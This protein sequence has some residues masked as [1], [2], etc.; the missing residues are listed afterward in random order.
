[1]DPWRTSNAILERYRGYL[2]ARFRF[3]DPQLQAS[4]KEA[5]RMA[6]LGAGP[7][8]EATPVYRRGFTVRQ[9]AEETTSGGADEGFIR[10]IN[11]DRR[12]YAH[13]EAAI[14]RVLAGRNV[15]VTTGT[16]SG[17]TEAFLLPILFD[18][19]REYLAGTLGPGVRALILYPMNAL[20]NDQR[21]RLREI[22]TQLQEFGS[23]FRFTFGQYI[24]ATPED[25]KDPSRLIPGYGDGRADGELLYREEIRATPPNILL[26]NYSMLEYL[27]IRPRDS[28]LFDGEGAQ[29]WRFLVVD[30]AHQYRGVQ[31][32][33]LALL[34][35]RLKERL[36]S[37]GAAQSLRCIG[38]SATIVGGQSDRP[39]AAEF[40]SQ[41]FGEPFETE[42]V[43]LGETVSIPGPGPAQLP[44]EDYPQL[45]TARDAD[46]EGPVGQAVRWVGADIVPE[47][48]LAEALAAVLTRDARAFRLRQALAEGPQLAADLAGRFFPEQEQGARQR[49]LQAL[50][51]LLAR[52][53]N[54]DGSPLVTLRYHLL[55]SSLEGAF[56]QYRP[57]PRI[58][59]DR[60]THGTE[61]PAFE[62][63]LCRECGEHYLVGREREGRLVEAVHDVSDPAFG[64]T[65]F[66]TARASDDLRVGGASTEGRAEELRQLC[67]SCGALAP[68]GGELPCGHSDTILLE[69]H[70]PPDDHPD[71][72]SSCPACLYEHRDPVQEVVY[73]ADGPQAV[74]VTTL[75]QELPS[76]RRRVL[77]FADSR[78]EAAW[79]AAYV[80]RTY[81]ELASR[82]RILRVIRELSAYSDDGVALRDM[83]P[84]LS[85]I[86]LAERVLPPEVTALGARGQAWIEVYREFLT[87]HR[88]LSLE[89][90]GLIHWTLAREAPLVVPEVLRDEP[91]HLSE[92]EARELCIGLLRTLRAERAVEL[93]ADPT[94]VAWDD[95]N[96]EGEQ[97]TVNL[98]GAGRGVDRTRSWSRSG[99]RGGRR[100]DWLSRILTR[101]APSLPKPRV[102]ENVDRALDLAWDELV[103]ARRRADARDRGLLVRSGEGYRLNPAWWR[104]LVVDGGLFQ[105]DTCG[106]LDVV[107]VARTCPRW[108]CPG[109]LR[110][111]S[112]PL[113]EDDHYRRLYEEPLPPRLRAEEHTAQLSRERAHE[114]QRE[115]KEGEIEL[116]SSSTTF[117]LGVD[118]GDLDAV[119]LRNVP[120]EP[121]NY[122]QRAGRAGR[123]GG[124]PGMVVTYC[125]RNPHDIYHFARPRLAIAGRVVPPTVWTRNAKVATR[126]MMATV[127]ASYFRSRPER[128]RSAQAFMGDPARPNVVEALQSFVD[129][130][131]ERI[132]RRLRT[133][134][135]DEVQP[136]VGLYDLRWTS[137]VV[138]PES[139]LV[140]AVREFAS[141]YRELAR[142]EQELSRA[143]K[144]DDAKWA[145]LRRKTLEDEDVLSFLSRK[146]VI[147][148]Y[149]FP[150][151][152]VE[153]D[154]SFSRGRGGHPSAGVELSRDL[155]VAIAEFAPGSSV[156][157]DK[158]QWVSAGLKVVEEREWPWRRYRR[159]TVHNRME[160]VER[161]AE[162]PPERCCDSTTEGEYVIPAFGFRADDR[163]PHPVRRRPRRLFSTRPHFIK[164]RG[165]TAPA[166]VLDNSALVVSRASP[167]TMLVLCDGRRG[168]G[169]YICPSCGTGLPNRAKTHHNARR[170]P[171]REA[172]YRV[173]LGHEFETDVVSITF[174]PDAQDLLALMGGVGERPPALKLAFSVA[175][176]LVDSLAAILQV[177][178]SD[179]NVTVSAP[180][181]EGGFPDIIVYDDVPGGA[182]LVVRMEDPRV[183]RNVLEE[184][185]SRLDGRCGCGEVDSCYGCLRGF[186][187]QFIH[188]DLC[189]GPAREYVRRVLAANW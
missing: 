154:T 166:P 3:R 17:K 169:F 75:L 111:R 124:N 127:L 115:F 96:L 121:F 177:P 159:C 40:A 85:N 138:G 36:W 161:L 31:G 172:L 109:E 130:N 47:R 52:A 66:R 103:R 26:T 20:A 18:L 122:A 133:I 105:C 112:E 86:L 147:P 129:A 98:C 128:F 137:L 188:P 141:D 14:R 22:S 7:F 53:R 65:Y 77:A 94:P 10:A 19:Y 151:D 173:S 117:E 131:V 29:R 87:Q 184:A 61:A 21:D 106:Y 80:E 180:V 144:Y 32:N 35:R 50:A 5:L 185:V 107:S 100:D 63:A 64:V 139:R 74:V 97:A 152:V 78:Q 108:R 73:G 67:V 116:L 125:R 83:V 49:S 11:G 183:L 25:P 132:Q 163:S 9:I 81:R 34:I 91:W 165:G 156:I 155:A 8:I 88:R 143:G 60:R 164:W 44:C 162:F 178:T 120:P 167:G 69:R 23:P 170:Q 58:V 42:D 126:H 176:S 82:N 24:G 150:V 95:L 76:D 4:F 2:A 71:S 48:P 140:Q 157:A 175:Y 68:A 45:L 92:E 16:A 57:S 186:R 51:S 153:L 114:F 27:L 28:E 104:A 90:M 113:P 146:A 70:Q 102:L 54:A 110:P 101:Q 148:K 1:M 189:R 160:S 6:N 84:A 41:L 39:T 93:E 38:T 15:L 134:L 158:G 43:I 135:P 12:L 13:Q 33:E 171:C 79:F 72:L 168:E 179:L 99:S 56:I 119:F 123:R 142:M 174:K 30:E 182:G 55:L 89:G 59:L 37:G 187:N 136:D 181:R 46:S 149:G 118:L 145:R 62:V